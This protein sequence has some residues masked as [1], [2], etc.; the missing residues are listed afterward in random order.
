[1]ADKGTD[2]KKKTEFM[3]KWEWWEG[4]V[5]D[6]YRKVLEEGVGEEK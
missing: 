4:R 5:N 1:M 6:G 3:G 2:I